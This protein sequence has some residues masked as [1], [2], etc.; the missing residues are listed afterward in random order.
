MNIKSFTAKENLFNFYNIAK[1]K[2]SLR[3]P[4][5]KIYINVNFR[6]LSKIKNDRKIAISKFLLKNSTKVNAN[7][8]YKGIKYPIKIR[9]RGIFPNIGKTKNNGV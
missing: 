7:I 8:V 3:E 1:N 2:F 5:D 4:I 6:N 9:L